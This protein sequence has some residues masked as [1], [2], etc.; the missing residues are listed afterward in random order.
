MRTT[1]LYFLI[2]IKKIM[3][4]YSM[5]VKGVTHD[6]RPMFAS[7]RC[8]LKDV[9]ENMS[10]KSALKLYVVQAKETDQI[11]S[12]VFG[13]IIFTISKLLKMD[14]WRSGIFFP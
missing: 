12:Q 9:Q 3:Y 13:P 10:F 11:I 2:D 6:P 14:T 7:K 1:Q 8:P 5:N 4:A